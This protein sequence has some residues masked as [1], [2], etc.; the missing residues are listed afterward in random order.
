MV[1]EA[2]CNPGRLEGCFHSL[3]GFQCETDTAGMSEPRSRATLIP[4]VSGRVRARL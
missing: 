2:N 4:S 1:T 3:W